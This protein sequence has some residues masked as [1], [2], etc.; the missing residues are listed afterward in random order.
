M[1]EWRPIKTASQEDTPVNRVDLWLSGAGWGSSRV[2]DCWRSKG[3][4]VHM[5]AGEVRPVPSKHITH[6]MPRPDG[7][8]GEAYY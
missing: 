3:K 5:V 6:W 7:P 4:W 8:N 1:S 2:T